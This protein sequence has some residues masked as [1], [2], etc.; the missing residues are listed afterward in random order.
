MGNEAGLDV[1]AAKNGAGTLIITLL[2]LE[3]S[4]DKNFNL[5]IHLTS[6]S[7]NY[8]KVT[9]KVEAWIFIQ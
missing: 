2:S 1:Q 4:L 7:Q 3:F 8:S 9:D 6:I 5:P